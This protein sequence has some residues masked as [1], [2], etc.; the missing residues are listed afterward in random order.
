LEHLAEELTN[1][2]PG[3]ERISAF[4]R[5]V[6]DDQALLAQ[7]SPETMDVFNAATADRPGVRYGCVVARARPP[8]IS[9]FVAN[10]VSPTRQ[11]MYALYA[12]LH[13]Q[14]ARARNVTPPR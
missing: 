3:G 13:Q 6:S 5:D 1:R 2:T 11:A 4:I 7:L 12:W 8:T 10:G 14:I 9:G